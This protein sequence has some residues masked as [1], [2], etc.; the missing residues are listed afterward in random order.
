[1]PA[2][3]TEISR[4]NLQSTERS[5]AIPC[6]LPLQE[7]NAQSVTANVIHRFVFLPI[8]PSE[9]FQQTKSGH[10][11]HNVVIRPTGQF[12]K[13]FYTVCAN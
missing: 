1:M 12:S 7:V 3:L 11:N 13:D 2:Q 9:Q 10:G 5:I 8:C 4:L 6:R